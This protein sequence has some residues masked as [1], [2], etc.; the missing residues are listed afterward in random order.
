ML[1]VKIMAGPAALYPLKSVAV[2]SLQDRRGPSCQTSDSQLH[3]PLAAPGTVVPL[4][5]AETTI[6]PGQRL[7][8][9]MPGSWQLKPLYEFLMRY[10]TQEKQ[11]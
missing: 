10:K 7:M 2:A 6:V 1:A 5:A 9:V 8:R 11:N 4:L 3:L